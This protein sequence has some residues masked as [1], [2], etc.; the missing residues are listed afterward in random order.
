MEWRRDVV[1][2]FEFARFL[3][4]SEVAVHRGQHGFLVF[5]GEREAVDFERGLQH[6]GS[7]ALGAGVAHLG[8]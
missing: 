8:G 4:E 2:D 7:D 1:G 6:F 5:L 3:V